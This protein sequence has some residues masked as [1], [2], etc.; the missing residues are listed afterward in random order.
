M[1][2]YTYEPLNLSVTLGV[3]ANQ[4]DGAA[5]VECGGNTVLSTVVAADEPRDFM[6]FFPLTVEYREK[7]SAAGR[8]PGG[9]IKREGKLSDHE[10]LTSRL[11]DR[12]LRPFF[13]QFY[14]NEV[15]LLSTVYSSDGKMPMSILSVISASLAVN[16]SPIPFEGGPLGAVLV[17]RVDG[18]WVF[19]PSNEQAAR[20]DVS[21]L[22]V[23]NKTGICMVEG[24]C[25][26]ISEDEM[27]DL[28]ETAH[29]EIA[30]QVAWQETVISQASVEKYVAKTGSLDWEGYYARVD[31][32]VAKLD[33]TDALFGTK[34]KERKESLSAKK[35]IVKEAFA[36]DFA[37]GT[38]TESVFAYL[39][40]A[41]LKERL[42]DVIVK[43]GHRFDGRDFTTVRPVST[44]VGVLP[45]VHG[46]AV[47]NRGET[48]ALASVTLGTLQDGQRYETLIEGLQE[49]HFMLH[50]NFPSFAVG[51]AKPLR[52]PG[53]REI[54]H[55]YLAEN[56]LKSVLPE[57]KEFPYTVRSVVD[58]LECNGSS[59]M[60][61]VC[62]TTMALMDAGVPITE[63]V[64]GIAM[65]L[66]QD[67]TGAYHVMTDILG[68][69]DALGLM[70]FKVTGSA[71]GIR[72]IQ[73]DIKAKD[74]LSREL[75]K[76][77]LHDA[78]VARL[79]I[80]DE[81]AKVL[82][83]PRSEISPLAPK[84]VSITIDPEKI[85]I[86]IGPSGK[87]IKEITAQTD[88]QIDIN[89]DGVV[90]IYAKS[91]EAA[92]KAEQWIRILAGDIPVGVTFNG[93]IRRFVEFGLFVELVPGK[94]GLVHVSSIAKA[95]Q[96]H[97][98][99][100]Y[101]V[102]D[103]LRVKVVSYEK[104]SGRVKLVAPAL[105]K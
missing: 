104:D 6:G 58:I 67:S 33:V 69:E 94:D 68:T 101:K 60:A 18:E 51:E 32:E 80:L 55:G 7:V 59:S 75:L 1:R 63:M 5:W 74:G 10:V 19:N 15:Q 83:A 2:K 42:P 62:A 53:R 11:I 36:A 86:I 73:M 64:A 25:N 103:P 30:Q 78:R 54:G 52:G 21:I 72:A 34:K 92:V 71:K 84:V 16:L 35:K 38:L 26:G 14:F 105:E 76:K 27:V 43:K 87:M 4:A 79:G 37:A 96:P 44:T 98:T 48:Q 70:D 95:K 97:L 99:E 41:V 31:A 17:A 9:F 100:V 88:T 12:S 49:R 45:Q 66:I 81:M 50:Y 39:F 93:I 89:D 13:P 85:G 24:S 40:D 61:T 90:N 77:A 56:S 46:S 22:V 28:L 23:G 29:K 82:S 8:I 102:G 57:Q 91:S 3:Y 65:G 47:F 20:V